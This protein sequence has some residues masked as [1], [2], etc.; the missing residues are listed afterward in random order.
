MQVGSQNETMRIEHSMS[1]TR[2]LFVLVTEDE[3]AAIKTA[4]VSSGRTVSEYI[5]LR[6]LAR[7][8]HDA[9]STHI[10]HELARL[11]LALRGLEAGHQDGDL[12]TLKRELTRLIDTLGNGH[13]R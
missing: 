5:R 13:A 12:P 7:R 4:A 6:A 10:R 3:Y 1:R 9:S 2:R 8:V 11:G